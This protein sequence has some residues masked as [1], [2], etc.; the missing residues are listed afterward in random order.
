[1]VNERP[2]DSQPVKSL[3]E[4]KKI[5]AEEL[6]K[7]FEEL[8]ILSERGWAITAAATLD[9]RLAALLRAFFVD[10]E[11]TADEMLEG[12]GAISAF[13]ARIELAFLLG[14]ISARERRLLNLIRKIRNDFAHRSSIASF[15][16]SPIKE[17]CLELDATN[18][19]ESEALGDL[20]KP[21][22][23]FF[24]AF[25]FLFLVLTHRGQQLEHREE[26]ELISEDQIASIF[27]EL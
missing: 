21:Q 20:R 9:E 27:K 25:S 22:A 6:R 16:Q 2:E 15:S 5:D 3:E 4:L 14:L 23:R 13:A 11:R 1:M 26:T 18:I 24:A 10:D 7:S 8:K 12:T 17:K 19:L